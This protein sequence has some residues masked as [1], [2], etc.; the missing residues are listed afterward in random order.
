[1][2]VD[3]HVK[4]LLCMYIFT[5]STRYVCRSSREVP[6]MYVDHHVKYPLCM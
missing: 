3:L 6:V 4:Y 5:W 1:M 2:Y